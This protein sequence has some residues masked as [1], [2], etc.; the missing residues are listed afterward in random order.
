M[1]EALKEKT[2]LSA[3]LDAANETIAT[4]TQEM[5]KLREAVRV[6]SDCIRELCACLDEA[7]TW[8]DPIMIGPVTASGESL[9]SKL[10]ERI[11]AALVWAGHKPVGPTP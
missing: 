11:N 4:Q 1:F 8:V 10:L 3:E 6:R 7:T 2:R 9:R 5:A